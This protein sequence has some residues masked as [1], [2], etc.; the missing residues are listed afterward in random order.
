MNISKILYS[1][2]GKNIH[3]EK[4]AKKYFSHPSLPFSSIFRVDEDRVT[5]LLKNESK[6]AYFSCIL[7]S[8]CCPITRR[9]LDICN[10]A[11]DVRNLC[12]NFRLLY[13][14]WS[15]NIYA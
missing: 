4:E 5:G 2:N 11:V 12:L 6:F 8:S 1:I 15:I 10:Y 14:N 13:S 3:D 7:N 9:L